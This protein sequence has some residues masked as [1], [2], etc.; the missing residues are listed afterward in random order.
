MAGDN[1]TAP[2]DPM[3]LMDAVR[4][5]IKSEF[6]G[7]IPDGAWTELIKAE[8][9]KFFKTKENPGYNSD[10]SPLPSDFQRIVWKELEAATSA[11][12]KE[13]LASEEWTGKWG[14]NGQRRIASEAVRKLVVDNSGEILAGV[15]GHAMQSTI[16]EMKNRMM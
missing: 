15:L 3:Q 13:F 1:T 6:V 7:L 9:E 12:M 2:Y 4:D 5:R 10:R 16:E 11:K 14:D 8:A